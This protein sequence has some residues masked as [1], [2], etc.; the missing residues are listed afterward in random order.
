MN[1]PARDK[2]FVYRL[3]AYRRRM[4]SILPQTH[5][6]G[7]NPDGP[8]LCAATLLLA[9]AFSCGLIAPPLFW[10]AL[11]ACVAVGVA[12]LAYR[13]ST[14]FCVG[15]FLVT[16]ASLEMTIFDF[17]GDAMFQ[18][19][20]VVVKGVEI[21]LAVLCALRFGLRLDAF[22]PVWAFLVILGVGFVHGLYPT[23]TPADSL[24][25][26]VGSSAPFVF[27]FCRL[28]RSWGEAIIR[29]AKWC[30]LVVVLVAVPLSLAGVRPLFVESGGARLGGLG[31]PAF[32]ASVCLTA[33]YAC[34]IQL[35]R[36]GRRGDL[37]LLV[38]N[39]LILLL[40]GARAP[41]AYGVAVSGLSLV[42]IRSVA[43]PSRHRLLLGLAV[44]ILVPPLVLLA[45]ELDELRLFNIVVNETINL[46]GRTLLWPAF[47]AAADQ[48]PWFGWGIG[49]GNAVI[50]RNGPIVQILHT[51]AAHNEYLRIQV[52]GG[53]VGRAL[54]IALFVAWVIVNTRRLPASD[55]RIMR[56]A[57]VAFACHALTD[58]VLISTPA[59]A[60]FAFAT[61]VF[62]RNGQMEARRALPGPTR[63]A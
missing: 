53:Q 14:G 42:S 55:R 23:L 6:V 19:T 49:A 1:L 15:W 25:S 57:F 17:F 2:P 40:T 20:I 54:L 38:A 11:V 24:R 48:S 29:T 27:C 26:L 59:C 43:L 33:I 5:A 46:S 37:W 12:F 28:P 50:P 62:A 58:N 34:L 4:R 16:S 3:Q 39:F 52:E 22:N 51:W 45:G 7:N 41:L 61:A 44:A 63:V 9:V 36:E 30:P 60:M 31:H 56:L 47:E 35:Y 21:V 8:I 13:H 10:L 32:L 18:T